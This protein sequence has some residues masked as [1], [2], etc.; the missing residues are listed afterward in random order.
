MTKDEEQEKAMSVWQEKGSR[1][2][3]EITT[4]VGKTKIGLTIAAA[5]A[6]AM[7]QKGHVAKILIVTPTEN[8]RDTQWRDEAKKWDMESL[9]LDETVEM[10]CIQ[11]A[12]K[13]SGLDW[14]LV[15]VD[16]V[17][18]ALSTEYSKFFFNN[19]IKRLLGLTATVPDDKIALLNKI[20]PVV[21]TIRPEEAKEKDLISQYKVYN[22]AVRLTEKEQNQYDQDEKLFQSSVKLMSDLRQV[23]PSNM[24]QFAIESLKTFR[25]PEPVRLAAKRYLAAMRGRKAVVL[26]AF[27]KLEA[28]CKIVKAV[29]AEKSLVFAESIKFAEAI[30]KVCYDSGFEVYHS[31]MPDELR[32]D[33]LKRFNDPESTTKGLSAVKALDL[34]LNVEGVSLSLIAG[35]S[36]KT[37]QFTQRLGRA[38]RKTTPDKVAIC[39]NLY[40]KGTQEEKWVQNRTSNEKPIWIELDEFLKLFDK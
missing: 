4:G 12:Y 9:F 21:Y 18:V 39:V 6:W 34:G 11:S 1:G 3:L 2:T 40:C 36:S 7:A 14:D 29:K 20:A 38:V 23:D 10:I 24:L 13:L 31:K 33:V 25:E 19:T 30:L 15:I 32:K 35:G 26:N 17:H 27:E 5:L 22:V 16:E 28:S 37:L 8:L